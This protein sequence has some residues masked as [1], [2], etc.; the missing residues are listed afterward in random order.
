MLLEE[1]RYEKYINFIISEDLSFNQHIITILRSCSVLSIRNLRT[2]PE[3]Q[4][5]AA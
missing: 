4:K 2:A 5:E 3:I 1:T